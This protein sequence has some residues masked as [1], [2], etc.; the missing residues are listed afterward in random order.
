MPIPATTGQKRTNVS[1]MQI[2]DYIICEY[3]Q[4]KAGSTGSLSLLG[5]ATRGEIPVIG[6]TATPTSGNGGTFYFIKVDKGLL[7]GDRVV[8]HSISW[9]AVNTGG[10]IQG[11]PW[12]NGNIIPVM[13][14]DA[15]P[16]GVASASSGTTNHPWYAFNG[17]TTNYWYSTGIPTITSPEW[18]AYEFPEPKIVKRYDILSYTSGDGGR[19]RDWTFE[20]TND[21]VNWDVLDRRSNNTWTDKIEIII[22]NNTPYKKYRV[23]VTDRVGSNTYVRIGDI[24]MYEVAGIMRSLTG[25][26]AY[27]DANGDRALT[28]QG[29]NA[30]P[31]NNEWDKYILNFPQD[32]IQQGKGIGD[33]FNHQT[34]T[35]NWCQDT[36]VIGMTKPSAGTPNLSSNIERIH[37]NGTILDWSESSWGT[38]YN[39]TSQGFRPVFEYREV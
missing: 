10:F 2:G 6:M 27:A 16:S 11:R 14:G 31:T 20:G 26:V 36:P 19:P 34:T 3:W 17:D 5:T 22:D 25:G 30:W 15:T 18:I 39:G 9:E 1:D 13:T 28:N 8:N 33:V 23:H 35:V 4:N 29:Y 37:R 32:K 38:I 21:G 7:I 12:D 24:R